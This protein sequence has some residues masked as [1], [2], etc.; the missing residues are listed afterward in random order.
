MYPQSAAYGL[1]KAPLMFMQMSCMEAHNDIFDVSCDADVNMVRHALKK[2]HLRASRVQ[3]VR[4]E[5]G[6]S[7]P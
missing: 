3:W 4:V 2:W 1:A 6:Q 5:W 7:S